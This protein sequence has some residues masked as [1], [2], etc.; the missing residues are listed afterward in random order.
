M[1]KCLDP[2]KGDVRVRGLRKQGKDFVIE[3]QGDEDLERLRHNTALGEIGVKVGGAARL[4]WPRVIV[5]D[6]A[7]DIERDDLLEAV[8]LR[9]RDM[10]GVTDMDKIKQ[11]FIP[12]FVR[13]R[14]DLNERSW[15]VRVSPE[16]FKRLMRI[17]RLYVGVRSCRV[18]E[19]TSIT[20]C[21]K[22]Q[23]LGHVRKYCRDQE[24]CGHCVGP[25]Y[26]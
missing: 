26:Y 25:N 17:E 1:V 10:M 8:L 2:K 12:E 7:R 6:V 9:N 23:G 18:M 24:R 19:F 16:V 4:K 14:R 15:V 5:H 3:L 21:Y 22:C 11:E 13:G 20:R